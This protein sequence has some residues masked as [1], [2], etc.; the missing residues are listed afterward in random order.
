MIKVLFANTH[1]PDR[2]NLWAPW[3]KLAN[4]AVSRS[5]A[6][7]PEVVVPRAYSLP[8]K[9]FPQH[10]SCSLPATERGVEGVVHYPRF[11]YLIPKRYCYAASFDLY[12]YFVGNY[13]RSH[14]GRKDLVHA[15]HV[16]LDGYGMMDTCKKWKAPL[17]VDVHGDS[18]FTRMVRDPLIGRKMAET[19][20]YSS[21]VICI[22]HNLCRL[23]KSFGIDEDRIEYVP[24]GI[25]VGQ[26]RPE[27]QDRIKSARGLED[28][29]VILYVG[30]LI[31]R[32]GVRHLLKALAL[33]ET[34]LLRKCKV[35]IVGDGPDRKTLEWLTGKLG[36]EGL[37]AFT[38][39][40]SDEELLDWYAAADIFVLPSLSEGRPTVIN[41]SMASECAVI[42]SDVSGIPEQVTDGYNGFLVPPADPVALAGKITYLLENE[43]DIAALGRNGRRKIIDE[44]IT[45]EGYADRM[46][47]I[48]RKVTDTGAA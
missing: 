11:L 19:L 38:G 39:K 30:Q 13:V 12:S 6:V 9:F 32:K 37:V 20:K 8:L 24:L 23:A 17:I 28:K 29:I 34:A 15:H 35:V 36:L 16:F 44:R 48:Y 40:V 14:I 4:I 33:T 27:E 25:D 41:E 26:H 46:V 7:E 22:S 47:G 18:V 2:Y 31:E 45:W 10:E 21:K 42:A 5:R 3:N 43:N 1:Y